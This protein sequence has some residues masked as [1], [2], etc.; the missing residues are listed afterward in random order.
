MTRFLLLKME[1]VRGAYENGC[2]E[3]HHARVQPG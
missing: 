3:W 2:K 1:I